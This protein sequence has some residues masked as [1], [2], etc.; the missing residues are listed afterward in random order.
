MTDNMSASCNTS[1]LADTAFFHEA[2][3]RAADALHGWQYADIV[4]AASTNLGAAT[5]KC[6][7]CYFWHGT[8]GF[9]TCHCPNCGNLHDGK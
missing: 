5:C 4:A 9:H 2:L 7:E 3:A 1:H 6:P 8:H